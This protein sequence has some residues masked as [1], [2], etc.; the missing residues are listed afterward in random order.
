M[1]RMELLEVMKTRA[2][3]ATK[4]V[5]LA[6]GSLT[7]GLLLGTSSDG[8]VRGL[9]FRMLAGSLARRRCFK[10]L[11]RV[12]REVGSDIVLMVFEGYYLEKENREDLSI[13]G[14]IRDHPDAKEAI[15]YII[16]TKWGHTE[17]H[18]AITQLTGDMTYQMG[19]I[20]S[21]ISDSETVNLTGR[22]VGF[23]KPQDE[24]VDVEKA[25]QA[26]QE[27]HTQQTGEPEEA[28]GSGA[29]ENQR[30]VGMGGD[31]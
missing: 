5:F 19:E 3:K 22:F 25:E 24:E 11:R 9:A 18:W 15:I 1:D 12:V 2:F 30:D 8:T 13:D 26:G 21:F 23:F 7:P 6:Q 17:M 10:R 4:E 29:E 27:A 14:S 16:E 31:P 28:E 20:Q